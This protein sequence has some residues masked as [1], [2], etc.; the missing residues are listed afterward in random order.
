MLRIWFMFDNHTFAKI[1]PTLDAAALVQSAEKLFAKDGCGMLFV[2]DALG[3]DLK[4]LT[5]HGRQL[6]NR[7]WGV[8]KSDLANWAAAVL[9]EESFQRLVA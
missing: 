3:G 9:V 2:R 4:S 1:A 6:G 7:S 8:T 5:L